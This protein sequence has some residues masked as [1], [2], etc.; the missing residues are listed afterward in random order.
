MP[1]RVLT[2]RTVRSAAAVLTLTG[3]LLAAA[4][5]RVSAAACT[6]WT[7]YVPGGAGV[8]Q[9]ELRAVAVTSRQN[10]WA[11]DDFVAT[12]GPAARILHWTGGTWKPQHTPGPAG[13]QL[14][15]IA[16]VS[17]SNAWAAGD[18]YNATAGRYETV[19]LHW[20]GRS[21]SRALSPSPAGAHA[22][23]RGVAATSAS[24]V[25]AVGAYYPLTQGS[26]GKTFILHWNGHTWSRVPSPN[27]GAGVN[28]L[29][30]VTATA[31]SN[32]WAAGVY[33]GKT[34]H[35]LI[36]HWNGR[37]WSRQRSTSPAGDVELN[38]ISAISAS[39]AW[40]VG[41]DSGASTLILHWNG[42][43]WSRQP[44]PNG[45][46]PSDLYGVAAISARNVWAVGYFTTF[47]GAQ[48][49]Q[50][51]HRDQHGWSLIPSPNRSPGGHVLLDVGASGTGNIWAVGQAGQKNL[52][53]HRHC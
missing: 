20:N 47:T 30:S 4:P 31:R 49:T 48:R 24:D 42:H 23:L 15:G 18:Y 29:G 1:R 33:N 7:S 37:S 45:G 21:W 6:P 17:A 8:G 27:M 36:L 9:N 5:A 38:A 35:T 52:A 32:A 34:D 19:I 41:Q 22:F 46:T 3:S 10:A 50:I 51:V 13:L 53:L 26:Q 12:S 40:A 14:Y 11:V 28:A 44:S 25:W 39:S 16:A 43:R 2:L